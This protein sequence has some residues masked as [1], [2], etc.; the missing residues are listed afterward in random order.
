MTS[1]PASLA[2]LS[3]TPGVTSDIAGAPATHGYTVLDAEDDDDGARGDA[4]LEGYAAPAVLAGPGGDAGMEAAQDFGGGGP[5]G[6]GSG[7]FTSAQL[8]TALLTR[9]LHPATCRGSDVAPHA[10]SP[11]AVSGDHGGRASLGAFSTSSEPSTT[12]SLRSSMVRPR[13]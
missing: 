5:T 1:T 9:T 2:R 4:A 6:T 11:V 7:G 12:W 3:S 8:A 10:S 13:L